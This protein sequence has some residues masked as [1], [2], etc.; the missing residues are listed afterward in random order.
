MATKKMLSENSSALAEKIATTCRAGNVPIIWGDPGIGKTA[1]VEQLAKEVDRKLFVVIGSTMEPTDVAGL[2]VPQEGE[3]GVLESRYTDPDFLAFVRKY[4]GEV[5]LLFDEFLSTPP[6]V[7]NSLLTAIQSRRLPGGRFL[8][9]NVWMIL[10]SNPMEQTLDGTELSLPMSNR[11]VHFY[12]EVDNQFFLRNFPSNFGKGFLNRA[13]ADIR[14]IITG[15]LTRNPAM[16]HDMPEVG[17][18]YVGG[19]CSPRSW[20]NLARQVAMYEEGFNNPKIKMDF[21]AT[22]GEDAYLAFATYF[23]NDKLPAPSEILADP[24]GAVAWEDLKSDQIYAIL[25]GVSSFAPDN[26]ENIIETLLAITNVYAE[27]SKRL[28][29]DGL[30]VSCGLL[31]SL[32][33]RTRVKDELRDGTG[34]VL[35]K[36]KIHKEIIKKLMATPFLDFLKKLKLA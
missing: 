34:D 27:A 21:V 23:L 15:F 2:P 29:P 7:Q 26:P 4:D 25:A 33:L 6:V 28:S 17:S 19:W 1:M 9:D 30:A 36:S 5:I 11:L 31:E 10:A 13:E 3:D 18:G 24:K 16:I 12:A 35:K 22:V 32:F 20:D 14:A 8:P